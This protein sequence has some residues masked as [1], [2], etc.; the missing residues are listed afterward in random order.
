MRGRFRESELVE[1]PPHRAEIRFR[2]ARVALSPQAG[3]GKPHRS[4]IA[5]SVRDGTLAWP[6]EPAGCAKA[7]TI[8]RRPQFI[9][10]L[11]SAPP[12]RPPLFPPAPPPP[13]PPQA[14]LSG[15]W[16]KGCQP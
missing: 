11:A 9:G 13:K 6:R 4:A 12:P 7:C 5:A 15:T 2:S 16:A 10:L 14:C 3:R 8:I 1:T